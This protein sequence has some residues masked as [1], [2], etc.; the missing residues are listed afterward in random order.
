MKYFIYK[1]KREVNRIKQQVKALIE[2]FY[3][4]FL[5]WH[6]DKH[7]TNKLTVLD[8]EISSN[9]NKIAIF[10]IFQPNGIAPSIIHTCKHFVSQGY[11]P[12]V[13]SNSAL[14]SVDLDN[15]KRTSWKVLIRPNFGYDFGGYRD[16][17]W[18]LNTLNISPEFLI[19]INDSIWFPIFEDDQTINKMENAPA[20]FVGALQVD[21][22]RSVKNRRFKP[23]FMG[24][25]FWLF[26]EPALSNPAF[27]AFWN[28]YK[29]TSNKY[30]TI[31][32]GE[33]LFSKVMNDNQI[34]SH[35]MFSRAML[36][37]LILGMTSSELLDVLKNL[38]A[39]DDG[40]IFKQKQ[41]I[42]SFRDD[43]NWKTDAINLIF[44]LTDKQNILASAPI[45]AI[46]H[47][48]VSYIKKSGD[49]SN[50]IAMAK[51]YEQIKTQEKNG[52]FDFIKIEMRSRLINQ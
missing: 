9:T 43:S 40:L 22:S 44:D 18:L 36:D 17:I 41:C 25:F 34:Q 45:V 52:I 12:L 7:R 47:F 33:R 24:S 27:H 46:Q 5:R 11:L 10:L 8:G 2:F 14:L 15:L 6:Y 31:R 4:P 28:Q 50:L 32:R 38:C 26:K 35:A 23:P 16:G 39:V 1:F 51:I 48:G 3:E 49:Y 13:V 19:I 30:K 42:R 21:Q 37:Q 20:D 29:I